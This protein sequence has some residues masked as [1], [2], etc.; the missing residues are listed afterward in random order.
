MSSDYSFVTEWTIPAS[1]E[2]VWAALMSPDEWPSWWRGVIRVQLLTRGRGGG[3]VGSVR[4]Y[5]WRSRLPYNLTFDIETTRIEPMRVI[6]GRATGELEGH[7]RWTITADGAGTHV[8]YDWNIA[9][10]KPWMRLLSP[11]AKPI[12]AWN[13]DVIME[14]GREG[15]IARASSTPRIAQ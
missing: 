1:V 9:T 5:T 3:D 13:H 15:L 8:R 7:G 4:R 12:F 11:I 14:W 2:R 10:T 6:E